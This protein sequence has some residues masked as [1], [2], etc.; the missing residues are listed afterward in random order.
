MLHEINTGEITKIL[1]VE[2]TSNRTVS[3]YAA[4][5]FHHYTLTKQASENW[6]IVVDCPVRHIVYCS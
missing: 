6:Y 4:Y 3:V 2:I 1:L 5:Y